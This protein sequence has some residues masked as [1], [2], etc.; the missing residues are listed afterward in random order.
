MGRKKISEG[1][2]MTA[3][4]WQKGQVTNPNGRPSS[5]TEELGERIVDLIWE[6]ECKSMT[7]VSALEGMPT[8]QT[9]YHWAKTYPEFG[10]RLLEARIALGDAYDEE[11]E[12]IK[13]RMLRGELDPQVATVAIRTNEKKAMFADPGT[14]GTK[15]TVDKNEKKVVEHIFTNRIPVEELSEDELDA[16]EGALVKSKLLITGPTQN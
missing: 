3:T 10:A 4:A 16:L 8:R 11:N 5:F 6:A 13:N 12:D 1:G 14:F 7:A 9:L 2:S 15:S